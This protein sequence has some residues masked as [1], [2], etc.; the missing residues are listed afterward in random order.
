MRNYP[1][2]KI[3][4]I[5]IVSFIGIVLMQAFWIFDS[6]LERK[7][8]FNE[9]IYRI[10]DKTAEDYCGIIHNCAMYPQ[11]INRQQLLDS[12]MREQISHLDKTPEYRC[13]IDSV[14]FNNKDKKFVEYAQRLDCRKN[15][16]SKIFL[17]IENT[18]SFI[19]QSLIVWIVLSTLLIIAA[20]SMAAKNLHIIR[21]QKKL[22]QIQSDF[23][24]NM[25]HE[26][27]TPIA[28]ISVASEMLMKDR[29][30]DDREKS[31][32]YSKIIYDENT[33]LKKLVERVMQIA[34]FERGTMKIKLK[35][36]DLHDSIEK[37]CAAINMIIKDKK[38]TL[39]M[40]LKATDPLYKVDPT[41]FSNIITNLLENGIKYSNG[42]PHIKVETN[43]YAGGISISITDRGIGIAKKYQE[44]IFDRFF[45]VQQGDIHNTKGFG[46]GLYYVRRV[47][48]AH[49]GT[50]KVQS[51]EGSGSTFEIYL[52]KLH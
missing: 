22:S 35:E 33:R 20:I 34:L 5:S 28:T 14:G 43:D 30:L 41:H 1:I 31:K 12:I 3:S 29:V 10:L 24:G 18:G 9:H 21:K 48:E 17:L 49:G 26:L 44:R 47:V 51:E 36:I 15:D 19:I 46:L 13:K 52:P 25:T 39:E 40:H 4:I 37:A 23:I 38:G 45:R 16:K 32:R 6:Y 7:A 50:I 8:H 27:K 42:A 2:K 11:S